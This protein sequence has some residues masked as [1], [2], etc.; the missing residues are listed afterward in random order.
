MIYKTCYLIM[1][2]KCNNTGGSSF[3]RVIS[4]NISL[5]FLSMR[6]NQEM[7]AKSIRSSQQGRAT[8]MFF[9]VFL[10][11]DIFYSAAVCRKLIS[12]KLVEVH[13]S[14]PPKIS[15]CHIFFSSPHYPFSFITSSHFYLLS[16]LPCSLLPHSHAPQSALLAFFQFD[17]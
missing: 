15:L 5:P 2:C 16:P 11:F 1:I 3:S 13:F 10:V 4:Y 9:N 8:G 12:I 17:R 6:D 7:K 14:P